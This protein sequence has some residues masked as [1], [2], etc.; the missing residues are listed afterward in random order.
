MAIDPTFVATLISSWAGMYDTS[1]VT[2]AE[3]NAFVATKYK[4]RD[5]WD[6]LDSDNQVSAL[7]SAT[8]DIDNAYSWLGERYF[9]YQALQFPRAIT[10][11]PNFGAPDNTFYELLTVSQEQMD[12]QR[13][14]KRAT[15]EQAL[16]IIS[17]EGNDIHA[18]NR[19]RGI[20]SYSES[21]GSVSES[22]SYK[23]GA[24]SGNTLCPEAQKLLRCYTTKPKLLRG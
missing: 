7:L 15:M 13:R 9:Y 21:Q 5:I 1:Y 24:I 11:S 3:M 20:T 12:Q 19:A 8:Q 10:F 23:G 17:L 2:E 16:W 14:V 22:Y 6:D 18:Q 4:K